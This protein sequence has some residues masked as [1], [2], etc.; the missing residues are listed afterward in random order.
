[1][2]GPR[3]AA[4]RDTAIIWLLLDTGGRAGEIAGHQEGRLIN[5]LDRQR[6]RHH[7]RQSAL[8]ASVQGKRKQ[9]KRS[10]AGDR[11]ATGDP[12]GGRRSGPTSRA[13]GDP[14]L[15]D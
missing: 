3:A 1:V 14:P 11:A 6:T 7:E 4:A 15:D 8:L 5:A 2:Q 10:G 12:V 9:A 13:A